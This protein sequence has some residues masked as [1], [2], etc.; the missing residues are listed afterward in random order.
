MASEP[1]LVLR[2]TPMPT[3]LDPVGVAREKQIAG[4]AQGAGTNLDFYI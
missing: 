2:E 1:P 4:R 3:F